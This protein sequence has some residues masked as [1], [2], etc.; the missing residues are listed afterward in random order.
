MRA[1]IF[2]EV[3]FFLGHKGAIQA[4]GGWEKTT[5]YIGRHLRCVLKAALLSYMAYKDGLRSKLLSF[6]NKTVDPSFN[7][8][9]SVGCLGLITPW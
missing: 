1:E 3:F 6:L 7:L 9:S 2:W 8:E 5:A 4:L